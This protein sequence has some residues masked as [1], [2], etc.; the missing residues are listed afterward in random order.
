MAKTTPKSQADDLREAAAGDTLE[1]SETI[2]HGKLRF[3]KTEV[4]QFEDPAAAA[5]FDVAFN[6]TEYS[7]KE[8][9]RVVTNEELNFD[10]D[11]DGD[12]IDANTIIGIGREGVDPGTTVHQV[13][14]G[15]A[16]GGD[17]T[18]KVDDVHTTSAG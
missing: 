9:T 18:L 5:Y 14:T 7:D 11:A 16:G 10:P 15:E 8:P 4:V 12:T 6:G 13:I 2:L 1:F 17:A 3:G